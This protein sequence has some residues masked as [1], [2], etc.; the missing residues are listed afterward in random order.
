MKI[1]LH[2]G[3]TVLYLCKRELKV[4]VFKN[5]NGMATTDKKQKKINEIIG[6]FGEKEERS[7]SYSFS[8]ITDDDYQTVVKNEPVNSGLFPEAAFIVSSSPFEGAD[9]IEWE[10]TDGQICYVDRVVINESIA[11]KIISDVVTDMIVEDAIGREVDL[12]RI[13]IGKQSAVY[14]SLPECEMQQIAGMDNEYVYFEVDVPQNAVNKNCYY[15]T[16]DQRVKLEELL[17]KEW[18]DVHQSYLNS[19]I[20]RNAAEFMLSKGEWQIYKNDENMTK[21]QKE[22]WNKLIEMGWEDVAKAYRK[23]C[24]EENYS[25]WYKALVQLAQLEEGVGMDDD[26][27]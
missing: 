12:L 8:P 23:V 24:E 4:T 14:T 9:Q 1:N 27:E 21:E 17:E 18:I 16:E 25:E 22:K 6:V 13:K 11:S 15:F 7:Y 19:C 10:H 2:L 26:F 20:K 5:S 3:I